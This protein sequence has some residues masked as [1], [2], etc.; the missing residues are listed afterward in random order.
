MQL[1]EKL[2]VIVGVGVVVGVDVELPVLLDAVGDAHE[3]VAGARRSKV[4]VQ[5]GVARRVVV[6]LDRRDELVPLARRFAR[7]FT[8]VRH[9]FL[10]LLSK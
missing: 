4:N 7:A 9:L 8:T 2:L 5:L 3:E 10:Q 6:A 1:G